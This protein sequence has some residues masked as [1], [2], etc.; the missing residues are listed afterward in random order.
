MRALLAAAALV[1]SASEAGPPSPPAPPARLPPPPVVLFEDDGFQG[2]RLDLRGSDLDLVA[3]DFNDRTSSFWVRIGAKVTFFEDT[4]GQ[5]ARFTFNCST[6]IGNRDL[7]EYCE[8]KSVGRQV[9]T[10]FLCVLRSEARGCQGWWNDR[11]S[12]VRFD[13][14]ADEHEP[15]GVSDGAMR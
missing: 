9:T 4:G 3:L 5:G 15:A 10:G 6:P 13:G 12:G 14:P 8:V 11:I 2:R 1:L 7:G